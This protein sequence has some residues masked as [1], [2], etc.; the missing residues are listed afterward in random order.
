MTLSRIIKRAMFDHCRV[1]NWDLT[2]VNIVR[3]VLHQWSW[4]A[5]RHSSDTDFVTVCVIQDISL[6]V[7][8]LF[9]ARLRVMW[10]KQHRLH[11]LLLYP[12]TS[13]AA[14]PPSSSLRPPPPSHLS[15][16]SSQVKRLNQNTVRIQ[17]L[18]AP[19]L[20]RSVQITVLRKSVSVFALLSHTH[21][22]IETKDNREITWV[23]TKS[24]FK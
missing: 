12:T 7:R 13:G 9:F 23:N 17:M 6:D 24:S 10:W 21:V 15:A 4:K 8:W 20:W 14:G 16:S 19:Q 3:L 5:E 22:S 18:S 1:C 2:P 11:L